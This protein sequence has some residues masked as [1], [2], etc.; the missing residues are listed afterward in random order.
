MENHQKWFVIGCGVELAL[1]AIAALL[2]WVVKHPLFADLQWSGTDIV[3]GLLASLPLLALFV[4]LLG[5]TF[6]PFVEISRFLEEFLRPLF[7]QWSIAQLALISLLAGVGEEILF[8]GLIQDAL[9][10]S[11]GP[12]IA[13][14]V[15][16]LLFGLL[17]TITTTYF[18][19]ATIIGV[20]LGLLF[21]IHGNLL[22]PIVT[23]AAYDFFALFYFLRICKE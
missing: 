23:H 9:T 13:I 2:S 18:I 11:A 8:R 10:G 12:I 20:Y 1:V 22:V 3:T 16:S 19:M 7:N 21:W 4:W 14:G 17:H 6:D 15:A 5:S